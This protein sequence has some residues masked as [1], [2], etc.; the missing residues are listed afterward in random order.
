MN[1]QEKSRLGPSVVTKWPWDD[2]P[3]DNTPLRIWPE[4]GYRPA[5]HVREGL[6]LGMVAGCT[7][8]VFN[9][10]GSVFWPAVSDQPQHPLHLIQVYLTFPFGEAALQLQ[11]GYVLA[12]GCLLFVGTGMIYGALFVLG[13]SFFFPRADSLARLTICIGLALILW[14]VNFYFLLPW[15]QPLLFGGH[16]IVDLMPWWVAASTHLVFGGTIGS[17]CPSAKTIVAK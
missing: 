7:S 13:V 1:A 5:L 8:L 9:V 17:L 16:W 4:P 11:S 12:L 10:I 14:F 6:L 2:E 3:P 15:M